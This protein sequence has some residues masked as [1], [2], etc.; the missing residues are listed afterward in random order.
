MGLSAAWWG[1]FSVFDVT[2]SVV[3]SQIYI[4]A[5]KITTEVGGVP[6]KGAEADGLPRE[7]LWEG[8]FQLVLW[9]SH[10]GQERE[11]LK[12]TVQH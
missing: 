12:T 6:I 8:N 1:K 11:S 5:V 2:S 9:V 4:I 7:L 10:H 3:S